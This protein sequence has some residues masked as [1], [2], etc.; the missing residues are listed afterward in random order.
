LTLFDVLPRE[1]LVRLGGAEETLLVPQAG[2]TLQ[3]VENIAAVIKAD[4]PNNSRP[5]GEGELLDR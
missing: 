1:C 4:I 3:F 5:P 2:D